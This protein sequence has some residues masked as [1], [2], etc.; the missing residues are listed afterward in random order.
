VKQKQIYNNQHSSEV[1]QN[2]QEKSSLSHH[3]IRFLT[4][5]DLRWHHLTFMGVDCPQ[6]SHTSLCT[7]QQILYTYT[8]QVF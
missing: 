3:R 2:K 5:S 6:G 7:E 4:Y 1:S 8:L